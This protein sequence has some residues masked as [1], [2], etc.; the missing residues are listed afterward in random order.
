MLGAIVAGAAAGL[1][2]IPHCA[3]MCGPLA[4]YACSGR[5]RAH[6]PYHLGRLASYAFTG[7]LAGTFGGAALAWLERPIAQAILSWTLALGLGL[8]AWRLWRSPTARPAEALV[9]LRS[10]PEAQRAG[11]LRAPLLGLFTGF[12]P[13]GALAHRKQPA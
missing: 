2:S 1:A 9:Q 13:C 4:A 11:R 10:K 8:A 7:A 3:G 5:P 12:L 6:A